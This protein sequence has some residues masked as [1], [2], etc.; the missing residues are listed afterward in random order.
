[1]KKSYLN[2]A[3]II[4]FGLVFYLGTGICVANA[5]SCNSKSLKTCGDAN[6]LNY[7][8][9]KKRCNKSHQEYT[10]SNTES[11]HNCKWSSGTCTMNSSKCDLNS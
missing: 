9:P 6:Y 2:L 1:M 11:Y 4:M 5:S 3:R 8:N 7:S 10:T